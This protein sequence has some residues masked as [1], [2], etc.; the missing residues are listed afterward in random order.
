MCRSLAF[1]F[2]ILLMVTPSFADDLFFEAG[3]QA[4]LLDKCGKCHSAKSRKADLGLYD[5]R[6]VLRGGESG[7][8]VVPEQL[9]ESLLWEVIHNQQMPPKDQA[10]L[11]DQEKKVISD[12]IKHGAHSQQIPIASTAVPSYLDVERLVLNAWCSNDMVWENA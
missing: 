1:V 6:S 7:E 2:C 3:V 11:T 10:Q 9:E 4:I 12:W 8:V 5:I